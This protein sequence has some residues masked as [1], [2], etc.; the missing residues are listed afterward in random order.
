M[1]RKITQKKRLD[2]TDIREEAEAY[3]RKLSDYCEAF[4][5]DSKKVKEEYYHDIA[6]NSD[7]Y[8]KLEAENQRLKKQL[9]KEIHYNRIMKRA[10]EKYAKCEPLEIKR[11][12]CNGVKSSINCTMADI[13]VYARQVLK[14]IDNK[15]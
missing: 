9:D 15:E 5:I 11:E 3:N 7:E 6:I 10:L 12:Y 2:L 13:E 8:K 1:T 4:G 14:E